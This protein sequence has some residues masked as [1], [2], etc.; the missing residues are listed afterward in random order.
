MEQLSPRGAQTRTRLLDAARDALVEGEGDCAFADVALRARVSAGAPY[1]Y[2]ESKSALLV[3]LVERFYDALEEE[4]YRPSFEAQAGD[5]WRGEKLRIEKLVGY[6][7]RDALGVLIARGL[8]GDG[9][10]A[11]VQRERLDRQCK[12]AAK[13][14]ARGQKLGFVDR[15]L[16]AKATAAFLMGGIYQT[17]AVALSASSPPRR[18]RMVELVQQFMRR[19]IGRSEEV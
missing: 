16:D 18:K 12:G 2:F 6:F 9:D 1:R 7:Y 8:A 15:T 4:C 3:A 11:R 19:V 5:W 14:I 17:L 10:V 13:N